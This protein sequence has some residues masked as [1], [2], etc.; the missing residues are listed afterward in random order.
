MGCDHLAGKLIFLIKGFNPRTR[1]GCDVSSKLSPPR[2]LCF[3][4]RTRVGCDHLAGKLIFLIKGF[5]P[6]TRVG[7][8]VSSK[9]SP[10]RLLCFNPRTRVGCDN[11]GYPSFFLNEVSIHAPAWGATVQF[12][13]LS[14]ER[15]VS[16][17]APAWGATLSLIS[18]PAAIDSFNPRTRVGC[19]TVGASAAS[20]IVRFQSTHPRGVRLEP[21]PL[22]HLRE[23]VSIHAPAWGATHPGHRAL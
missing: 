5:N 12:P 17:H 3:N 11:E 19:D 2:L 7:C 13:D 14:T 23:V 1:V 10:P 15:R 6:R 4:P 22:T 21:S 16:I 20:C 9:L 18:L 8:D